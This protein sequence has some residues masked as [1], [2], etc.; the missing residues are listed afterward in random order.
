MLRI[1]G[2]LSVILLI[3][4]CGEQASPQIN[5]LHAEQLF[6]P[7]YTQQATGTTPP[8]T[9]YEWPYK[10]LSIGHSM[11][12]YQNYGGR[13]Y[14]HHGL[15]IRGDAGTPVRASAGGKVVNIENYVPGNPAYWEVAIL[16][17]NG[18]IWQYH[19]IDRKSIPSSIYDAYNSGEPIPTG[20]VI[21]EI[22]YWSV[23]TFGERFHHVHLNILG[24]G[25]AYQNPF[26]FLQPLA[27][28]QGP[29]IAELALLKNGDKLE[30]DSVNGRYTVMATIHDLILHDRF[31]VPPYSVSI[32]IDG[33]PP[34]T[35]WQFDNLPGGSSNEE[36]VHDLFVR[37]ET[38]GN[39]RCRNLTIDLG[40][41][42]AGSESFTSE[43]GAHT[44]EVTAKDFAGNAAT[45]EFSWS[46]E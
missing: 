44:V 17:A 19:H 10:I 9:R 21:G 2:V 36:H 39:Y 4:G 34:V 38:C 20:T 7:T 6:R 37:K 45:R 35:V 14:F 18:F 32:R 1:F 27:D 41:D 24:E 33:S 5:D 25:G 42:K 11:A 13:P 46:V 23:V 40:F 43:A 22:Y 16:D 29:K 3:T 8:Q 31:V 30:G 26:A 15:D 28:E 12:S